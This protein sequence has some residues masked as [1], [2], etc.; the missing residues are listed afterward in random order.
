VK[1]ARAFE[2]V[3]GLEGGH[4]RDPRDPGGET[5][6]G[7]SKRSYP[8][9]DIAALTLEDAQEIYRRDYWYALNL[10]AQPWPKALCLFDCAVNMG[11]GVALELY[12]QPEPWVVHFQ[13][14]R[15]LRYSHMRHWRVYGRGWVRRAVRIAI[16]ASEGDV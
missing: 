16:E 14:A 9:L 6:W 11:R 2:V 13:A 8:H 7:I 4:V 3:V 15:I 10:N 12:Q 1:F 5:K